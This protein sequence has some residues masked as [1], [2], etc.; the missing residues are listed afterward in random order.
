VPVNISLKFIKNN[1]KRIFLSKMLFFIF[2]QLN[3]AQYNQDVQQNPT[4][5][6]E[7]C[8]AVFAG[9]LNFEVGLSS[10]LETTRRGTSRA[11]NSFGL[12]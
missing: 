2:F 10:L 3:F 11:L 6:I 5:W 8:S 4:E 12:C 1:I 7:S 9:V